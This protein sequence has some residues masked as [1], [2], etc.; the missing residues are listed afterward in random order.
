MN[1]L[2]QIQSIQSE[3]KQLPSNCVANNLEVS[4]GQESFVL[5]GYVGFP[6]IG[7][8]RLIFGFNWGR[9]LD[10]NSVIGEIEIYGDNVIIFEI[11]KLGPKTGVQNL[12]DQL[13]ENFLKAM[14]PKV[15]LKLNKFT[16]G[17]KG[18][19]YNGPRLE[20]HKRGN[21]PQN[22][23]FKANIGKIFTSEFEKTGRR[24]TVVYK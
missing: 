1:T 17:K 21:K 5:Q 22:D 16:S 24:L 11:E 6:C 7:D 12:D 4:N 15:S 19:G 23:K 2:K 13:L 14:V 10:L 9:D 20:A 18:G 3:L 8:Q